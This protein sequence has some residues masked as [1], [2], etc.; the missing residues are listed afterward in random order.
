MALVIDLDFDAIDQLDALFRSLN[1]FGCEFGFRGDERDAAI[2]RFAGVRVGG[3][4]GFG[5]QLHTP[6]ILFPDVSAQPRMLDI[7]HGDDTGPGRPDR[8][9]SPAPRR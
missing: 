5:A 2:V 4:L 7:A 9:P 8:R 3:D 1:L 6:E